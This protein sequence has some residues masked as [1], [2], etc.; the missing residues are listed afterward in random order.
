MYGLA[1]IEGMTMSGHLSNIDFNNCLNSMYIV[2]LRN[3]Q[4]LKTKILVK[5]R[6][7]KKIVCY[8]KKT[9]SFF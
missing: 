3:V 5:G 9:C 4:K 8:S 7:K 2:D 1:V 6:S